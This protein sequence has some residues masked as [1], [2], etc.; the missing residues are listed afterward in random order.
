MAM[1][2]AFEDIHEDT[3]ILNVSGRLL[4]IQR[5]SNSNMII[6]SMST[7]LASCVECFWLSSS[8]RNHMRD[9]L[10]LYSG[11]HGMRVWLPVLPSQ[12]EI[13]KPNRHTFMSKRIML[14]FPLKLYPLIILF[15]DAIVL[16][17]ENDTILYSTD[18]NLHFS[19]PFSIL[20][21]KSQVYL[22]KILRQLIKRN[23]GYTAWEIARCCSNLPYFP[24]SLELLLHETLSMI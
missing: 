22:H 23:L 13:R 11:I 7:C 8:E 9:C 12:D 19:L 10:W 21:K 24:H 6:P 16:G 14:S 18:N 17:V 20:N 1:K 5:T 3:I 2:S 15:D 4:M